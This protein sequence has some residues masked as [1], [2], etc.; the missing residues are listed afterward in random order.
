MCFEDK[1]LQSQA[2]FMADSFLI[3]HLIVLPFPA[4]MRLQ[5]F[6]GIINLSRISF[7]LCVHQHTQRTQASRRSSP[8]RILLRCKPMWI[9]QDMPVLLRW[10]PTAKSFPKMTLDHQP[11]AQNGSGNKRRHRHSMFAMGLRSSP[12]YPA[13][14][15]RV[16]SNQKTHQTSQT[17][18]AD[19]NRPIP[20]SS[21]Q[22]QALRLAHHLAE[23]AR[24]GLRGSKAEQNGSFVN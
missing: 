9:S 19:P 3:T 8:K 6:A 20:S 17:R 21:T 14:R 15:H 7:S 18:K 23:Q 2:Y 4:N 24:G 1:G 5:M 11:H 22:R 13:P 10:T 12:S 16:S